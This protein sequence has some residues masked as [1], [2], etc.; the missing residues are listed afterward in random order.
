MS[1]RGRAAAF[2]LLALGCAVL[3]AMIA[4]GYGRRREPVRELR[5]VLVAARDLA[6]GAVIDARDLGR[7]IDVRRVPASFVP[8]VA[9]SATRSGAPGRT[10]AGGLVPAR[11][12]VRAAAPPPEGDHPQLA[13]GL[14]PVEIAV[15]G[16]DA[17][18]AAGESCGSTSSSPPSPTVGDDGRTF[19][20]ARRV[21]LLALGERAA[22]A[23][24]RR[25]WASP[26]CG[27]TLALTR[28]QALRL[29]QAENFAR[30]V[31]LL[32]H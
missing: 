9:R 26:A 1:R 14:R 7:R 24:P 31:R 30:S 21:R 18:G 11:R 19:I 27:A 29:I 17:L 5:P 6:R 15:T 28:D 12:R 16:A 20:A 2:G 13:D 8:P 25:G 23:T 3:A 4:N 10:A 22:R 32:A